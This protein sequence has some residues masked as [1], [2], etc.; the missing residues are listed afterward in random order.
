M[1]KILA[2][3]LAA[4]IA[5]LPMV[6]AAAQD[7]IGPEVAA[8]PDMP[9]GTQVIEGPGPFERLLQARLTEIEVQLSTDGDLAYADRQGLHAEQA[10]I[11][12]QLARVN[13]SEAG[14]N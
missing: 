1:R 7:L 13:A 12:A 14:V 9:A 10:W 2:L 8:V 3:S 5:A 11:Y 4:G 6:P